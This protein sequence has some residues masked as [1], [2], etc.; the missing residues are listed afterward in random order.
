MDADS[1]NIN[2]NSLMEKQR[3]GPGYHSKFSRQLD[4]MTKQKDTQKAKD[5]K[6]KHVRVESI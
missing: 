6:A 2:A 3:K 1:L 4:R 5:I